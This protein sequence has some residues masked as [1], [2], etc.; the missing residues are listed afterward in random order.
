MP[1]EQKTEIGTE[2]VI[3][4]I[5]HIPYDGSATMKK[6]SAEVFDPLPEKKKSHF[7]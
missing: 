5:K 4:R 7:C 3:N 1:R 6:F 2:A